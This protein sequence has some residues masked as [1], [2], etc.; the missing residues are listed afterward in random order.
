MPKK[1]GTAAVP[2]AGKLDDRA[3]PYTVPMKVVP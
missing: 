2:L 1:A 3:V